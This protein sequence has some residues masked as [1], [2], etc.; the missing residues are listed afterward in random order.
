M[1]FKARV[2]AR[3]PSFSFKKYPTCSRPPPARHTLTRHICVYECVYAHE[4]GKSVCVCA[5]M[6]VAMA[7]YVTYVYTH[8]YTH[9]CMYLQLVCMSTWATHSKNE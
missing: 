7:L 6:G 2:Y 8:I 1:R 3:A 9:T 5:R 4:C